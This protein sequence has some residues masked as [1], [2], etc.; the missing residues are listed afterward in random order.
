VKSAS[1]K[2]KINRRRFLLREVGF[3]YGNGRRIRKGLDRAAHPLFW[4]GLRLRIHILTRYGKWLTFQR[5][6]NDS[7][8]LLSQKLL[9][10][11]TMPPDGE[12]VVTGDLHMAG[13]SA[14]C[15][16][17]TWNLNK[18]LPEDRLKIG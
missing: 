13:T 17:I 8:F 2:A 1:G 5:S 15:P 11:V 14:Q 16:L 10:A 6:F 3:G 7:Q 4:P 9:F 18:G 12:L